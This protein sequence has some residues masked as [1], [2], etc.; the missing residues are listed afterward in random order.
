MPFYKSEI[1]FNSKSEEFTLSTYIPQKMESCVCYTIN[2]NGGGK[3]QTCW[4]DEETYRAGTFSN[5][6]K[7]IKEEYEKNN[8]LSEETIRLFINDFDKA[9]KTKP[10]EALFGKMNFDL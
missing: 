2:S 8:N 4:R 5:L 6:Y 10:V 1:K 3:K 9:A 7:K